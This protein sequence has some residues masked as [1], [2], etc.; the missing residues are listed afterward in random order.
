MCF[1]A[2]NLSKRKVVDMATLGKRKLVKYMEREKL[3]ERL[4]VTPILEEGQIGDASIDIRVGN[5]FVIA[6]KG[7]LSSIDPARKGSWLKRY[8]YHHHVNIG[9]KFVLHPGQLVLASTLEYLRLPSSLVATVT[10]RSKWGR[11]GLVIAT[12]TAIHPG[13]GGTIT[14]EMINLGEVPLIIYPGLRVAQLIFSECEGGTEYRG[15][16]GG[17]TEPNFLT[18]EGNEKENLD[19]WVQ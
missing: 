13:F 12:A 16:Y 7:H 4:V 6:R 1:C 19:F 8:Q 9:E 3:D 10:S 14:L 18:M 11:A 2:R 5:D 17:Q 15:D